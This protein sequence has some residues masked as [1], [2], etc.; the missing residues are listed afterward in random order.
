MDEASI[1]RIAGSAMMV[2]SLGVLFLTQ[3][4]GG[5]ILSIGDKKVEIAA[6]ALAFLTVGFVLFMFPSTPWWPKQSVLTEEAAATNTVDV[7]N[8]ETVI[9]NAVIVETVPDPHNE[10]AERARVEKLK[11]SSPA[12]MPQAELSALAALNATVPKEARTPAWR[13]RLVTC[14]GDESDLAKRLHAYLAWELDFGTLPITAHNSDSIKGDFVSYITGAEKRTAR[15]LARLLSAKFHRN[16][17]SKELDA[18]EAFQ[19]WGGNKIVIS[20][21]GNC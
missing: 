16:F 4:Q 3:A 1:F 10:T 17:V 14:P 15:S 13:A 5:I 7:S 11:Q 12:A 9:E 8:P 18:S 6:P 21:A 2:A 20:L 19:E